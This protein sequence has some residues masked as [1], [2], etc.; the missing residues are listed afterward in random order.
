MSKPRSNIR[1]LNVNRYQLRRQLLVNESTDFLEDT[2]KSLLHNKVYGLS[3]SPYLEG[4]D[5][6]EK[7]Q[8]SEQQI[9]DRLEVIR[10]YTNWVRIFSS[11]NG[12][13]NVPR[14]AKEKSLK[15]MVGA[16]L[17][18]DLEENEIEINN[19]IAIAKAGHADVLAIGNEVMLRED[20]EVEQLIE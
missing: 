17:S 3:F 7:A 16:W 8:I 20:L 18:A 13:E 19:A 15:T 2:M 11:S 9:A 6:S 4:Q 1:Y 5:P 14:I 12:N 10:P